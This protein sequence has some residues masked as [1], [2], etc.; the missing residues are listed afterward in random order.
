MFA[1]VWWYTRSEGWVPPP[2]QIGG[3]GV[4]SGLGSIVRWWNR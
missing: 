3:C 2:I 4:W 1:T